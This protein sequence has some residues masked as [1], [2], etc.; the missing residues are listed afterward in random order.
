MHRQII[1]IRVGVD[2]SDTVAAAFCLALRVSGYTRLTPMELSSFPILLQA[3]P[4]G[5]LQLGGRPPYSPA[6][7]A[8]DTRNAVSRQIV[9]RRHYLV[10]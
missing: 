3:A 2:Y 7:A 8:V 10:N 1:P 5:T 6:A 9:Y 4:R